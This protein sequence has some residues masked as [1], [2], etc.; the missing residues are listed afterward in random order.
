[1]VDA[2]Q[3][4]VAPIS[5][6]CTVGDDG[7]DAPVPCRLEAPPLA[8]RPVVQWSWTAPGTG[9]ETFGS[10]VMPLV[11]NFTDDDGNDRIDL[12][13]VPDVLVVVWE[14]NALSATSARPQGRIYLLSGD[15]GHVLLRFDAPVQPEMTPAFGDIDHD[16]LV[17]VVTVDS[18]WRLIIFEHDGRVKTRGTSVQRWRELSQMRYTAMALYDLDGDGSVEILG[19]DTVFDANGVELW[20]AP[21]LVGDGV[22]DY[23]APTPT[24]A[25]L[26][27]DG[28]LEVIF[29]RTAHRYDGALIWERS[30][31]GGSYSHHWA[32]P[33]VADVDGDGEPE[34]VFTS[35]F[36]LRVVE[37]DGTE[38]ALFRTHEGMIN[39]RP[40]V[41]HDFD[42][43]GLPEAGV[44]TA[45]EV[46]IYSLDP[47][48]RQRW[49]APVTD[50]T[51]SA[52]ATAFDFLGDGTPE[53]IYVDENQA[54]VF[55]GRDGT[56]R[57]VFD[58]HS[59]TIIEYP[60]VADVDAD[61]SAEIIITAQGRDG[62]YQGDDQPTVIV[63]R[64]A[65]DR[66]IPARRIWNQHGYHVTNVREDGAIPRHP[67]PAWRLQNTY[68][69]QA[70]IDGARVCVPLF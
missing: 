23:Q 61:G 59:S 1:M 16:G 22:H 2:G 10:K 25:D 4:G 40:A 43:D 12:C 24:A 21:P 6:E 54:H 15:D 64:D 29:G 60:V 7:L 58:R 46:A 67:F 69:A 36:G 37:A 56:E 52:A 3:R 20:R 11:G 31:D 19:G 50:W 5:D 30:G 18:E 41:L 27:G 44:A 66:W 45:S 34:V 38:G 65:E 49:A 14:A 35:P 39:A 9:T 47:S 17:E 42:G 33:A 13:D 48:H 68:R 51:G 70:Q 53:A 8:F 57:M 55:D 32:H 63:I 26:D 62:T 28:L